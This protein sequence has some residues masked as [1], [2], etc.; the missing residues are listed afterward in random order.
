MVSQHS[1][2]R[3]NGGPRLGAGAPVRVLS[4]A[5][6]AA[7]LAGLAGVWLPGAA[8]YAS[9]Q[10]DDRRSA[11]GGWHG[12]GRSWVFPFDRPA[13]P[14]GD[15]NQA[16]AVNTEDGSVDYSVDFALVWAEDGDPVQTK[17]EAYA[18]A[19]CTGCTTVAVGFQVVLIEEPTDVIAPEN[20]SAAVNYNCTECT[21]YALANQLVVSLG[22]PL[23][24]DTMDQL[25][26]LW[27][28]IDDYGDD[29][30]DV[31]LSGVQNQL[32]AYKA[33]ILTIIQADPSAAGD[34]IATSSKPA[35]G[36]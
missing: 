3:T 33:Q 32:E 21:T 1:D 20:L 29:L 22:G 10:H 25:S 24:E 14:D 18:F 7:L 12:S 2:D 23:T 30:E 13:R 17:N 34:G 9:G 8:A 19:S 4:R 26:A 31:P 28:E 15:G 5:A 16:L 35:A 36:A 11:P 27:C 6:V